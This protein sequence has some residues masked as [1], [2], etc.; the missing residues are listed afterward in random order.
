MKK[1]VSLL[2][3]KKFWTLVSAIVAA[4]ASYFLV[5]CAAQY[6]SMQ[7]FIKYESPDSSTYTI[8]FD[9]SGSAKSNRK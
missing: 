6:K 1:N 5:S 9:Q 7:R 2:R 3:S 8:I 4:L